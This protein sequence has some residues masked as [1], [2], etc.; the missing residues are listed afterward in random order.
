[1][2]ARANAWAI[3]LRRA[4]ITLDAR[5]FSWLTTVAINEALKLLRRTRGETS[6]G[7]FQA[8]A[9]GP[10]DTD[11]PEPA[12]TDAP[13]ADERALERIEHTERVQAFRMLKPREREALYLRALGHSYSEIMQLT[14]ASY[15]AV[16]RRITEGGAVLRD[17]R[18]N[19]H[20]T[21]RARQASRN[22]P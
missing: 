5:G 8:H 18:R 1:L 20:R 16:N 2:T 7:T 4:D 22:G 10:D 9:R 17:G 6:V 21:K 14:G 11:A 3:L 15:T 19:S 12:D 13:G